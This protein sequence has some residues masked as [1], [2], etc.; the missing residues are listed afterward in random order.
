MIELSPEQQSEEVK[1]RVEKF[2]VELQSLSENYKVQLLP[3]MDISNGGIIPV[4]KVMDL[5][6]LPESELNRAGRRANGK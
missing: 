2:K 5:K 3:V 4:L 6:W 1:D